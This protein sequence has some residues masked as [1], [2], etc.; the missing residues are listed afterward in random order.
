MR[1]DTI[2]KVVKIVS[3]VAGMGASIALS[4]SDSAAMKHEVAE[5]VQKEMAKHFVK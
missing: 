4:W 5:E 2:I 3:T 1:P